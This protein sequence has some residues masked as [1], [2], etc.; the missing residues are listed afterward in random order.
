[1]T[2]LWPLAARAAA[3]CSEPACKLAHEFGTANH[4]AQMFDIETSNCRFAVC[5]LPIVVFML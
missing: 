4:S 1:M 3:S 2:T 5:L